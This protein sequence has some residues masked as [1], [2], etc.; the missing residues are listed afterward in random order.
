[1]QDITI[2]VNNFDLIKKS[3]INNDIAD[4]QLIYIT[5][6]TTRDKINGIMI[7]IPYYTGKLI[8]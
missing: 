6:A 2:D 5:K 8:D 3:Q 1:M 7:F 4:D